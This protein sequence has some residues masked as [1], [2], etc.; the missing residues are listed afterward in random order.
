[1]PR[2][3]QYPWNALLVNW[4]PLSV[5]ILLKTPNLQMMDLMNLIVNCLLILTTGIASNHLVNLLMVTYR[6]RN[7][8][9]ALG[10]GPRMYNPHMANDHEG[11]I[12]C[13]IYAGV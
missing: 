3:S 13:S 1:M 6:Y 2:S 5:M 11:E 4:D 8:P 9:T 10:N 12:I 7:P